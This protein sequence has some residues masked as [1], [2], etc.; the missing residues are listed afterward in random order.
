MK[1][2]EP[3]QRMSVNSDSSSAAWWN[4]DMADRVSAWLQYQ[5]HILSLDRQVG[6]PGLW[7]DDLLRCYHK[8][9]A[10]IEQLSTKKASLSINCS[11][12]SLPMSNIVYSG[13]MIPTQAPMVDNGVRQANGQGERYQEFWNVT[14]SQHS[15]GTGTSSHTHQRQ[16]D[17]FDPRRHSYTRPARY[18][19]MGAPSYTGY[20][21]V[22]PGPRMSHAGTRIDDMTG[23]GMTQ[24]GRRGSSGKFFNSSKP[25]SHRLCHCPRC[26]QERE[27]QMMTR[28]NKEESAKPPSPQPAETPRGMPE[29][30]SQCPPQVTDPLYSQQPG[31]AEGHHCQYGDDTL[32]PNGLVVTSSDPVHVPKCTSGSDDED[33][34]K[35]QAENAERDEEVASASLPETD[36]AKSSGSS[37]RPDASESFGPFFF[38]DSIWGDHKPA[39]WPACPQAKSDEE[40]QEKMVLLTEWPDSIAS[41]EETLETNG[42]QTGDLTSRSSD[43]SSVQSSNQSSEENGVQ[44]SEESSDEVTYQSSEESS[45]EI[46]YQSSEESSEESNCQSE[47]ELPTL[48]LQQPSS[49]N[50][51]EQALTAESSRSTEAKT[52]AAEDPMIDIDGITDALQQI[53]EDN[54]EMNVHVNA[55]ADEV[56]SQNKVAMSSS[57]AS[58][59]EQEEEEEDSRSSDTD[60]TWPSEEPTPGVSR[61]TMLTPTWTNGS[62][63][64]EQI[65]REPTP[66]KLKRI[67]KQEEVKE[68]RRRM[69]EPFQDTWRPK[70]QQ[71]DFEARLK[72]AARTDT[73]WRQ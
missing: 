55:M 27:Q 73:N 41:Q 60:S 59:L 44:S 36:M 50:K 54:E 8:L 6:S 15:Y 21:R 48:E 24:R 4:V 53:N 16:A 10:T 52:A 69:Q 68:W 2:N 65:P 14:P 58:S 22:A 18:P 56:K 19:N 46:L 64:P 23:G 25:Y 49:P 7:W 1:M 12:S 51:G 66:I 71:A 38:T 17:S 45:E 11:S 34:E 30:T 67:Q 33:E 26:C 43:E 37:D 39:E 61:D 13:A 40:S 9:G 42:D 5:V 62:E 47:E 63:G 70:Q 3:F 72:G 35:N 28:N 32:V 31:Q 29:A 20:G 57:S